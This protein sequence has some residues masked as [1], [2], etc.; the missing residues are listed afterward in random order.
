MTRWVNVER[1]AQFL[2]RQEKFFSA[3]ELSYAKVLLRW[4]PYDLEYADPDLFF[5]HLR[6]KQLKAHRQH[7]A[8]VLDIFRELGV[9]YDGVEDFYSKMRIFLSVELFNRTFLYIFLVLN[10]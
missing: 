2:L 3:S 6:K 4:L 9:N 8:F 1:V 5:E 7:A 10:F